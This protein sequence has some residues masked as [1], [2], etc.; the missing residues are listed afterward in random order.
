MTLLTFVDDG[1]HSNL[2]S[3]EKEEGTSR[4]ETFFKKNWSFIGKQN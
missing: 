2:V 1:C 4:K 3:Q